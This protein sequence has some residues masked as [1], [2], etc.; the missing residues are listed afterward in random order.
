VT[1]SSTAIRAAIVLSALLT[2]SS[3]HA[4]CFLLDAKFV[5]QDKLVELVFSGTV[6]DVV[7]TGEVGYRATFDV[8][9][10]WK[11]TVPRR[12]DLHVW[13][14]DPEI[15]RFEKGRHYVALAH[16]MDAARARQGVG[17]GGSDA[18][19][20]TPTHC[21]ESLAPDIARDLGP[22]RPPG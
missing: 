19:A 17:L 13:E 22:G 16:R 5:M 18:V 10:V 11:G 7:R 1:L 3:A 20:F 21:S 4:E 2:A 14:L 8:D 12:F 6:V 15:P 9:R